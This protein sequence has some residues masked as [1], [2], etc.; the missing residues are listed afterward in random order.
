MHWLGAKINL[1]ALQTGNACLLTDSQS[2]LLSINSSKPNFFVTKLLQQLLTQITIPID[3]QWIPA[4]CDFIIH[5]E[6][7]ELAST[8]L[9]ENKINYHTL[10]KEYDKARNYTMDLK[11]PIEF[12]VAKRFI[13]QE[14]K[15]MQ[16]EGWKRPSN[17]HSTPFLKKLFPKT[18]PSK[19]LTFLKKHRQTRIINRLRVNKTKFHI[20]QK[21]SISCKKRPHNF[22]ECANCKKVKRYK[23]IEGICP[24]HTLYE[25]KT[26]ASI[27]HILIDCKLIANE[28]NY[29]AWYLNK[30]AKIE[31]DQTYLPNKKYNPQ[32]L[33][34]DRLIGPKYYL[35]NQRGL[36]N[37]SK[38]K[39]LNM[40]VKLRTKY[41]KKCKEIRSS[42]PNQVT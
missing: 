23:F 3:L 39:L 1:N 32:L 26:K 34:L 29:I 17:T 8:A 25:Q 40:I 27:K 20:K 13:L 14:T 10:K 37:N 31:K 4:H 28:R 24:C 21:I 7:D 41:D 33:T 11:H 2:V 30:K 36:D 19:Q 15:T 6:V 12:Q 42:L 9:K 18:L 38:R 22:D 5:D 16:I 35:T